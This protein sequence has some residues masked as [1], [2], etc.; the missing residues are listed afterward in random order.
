MKKLSLSENIIWNT[1][2]ST[3]YLGC[4]MLVVLF[5]VKMSPD[6]KNPGDFSLVMTIAN[7]LYIIAAY[8]I[9]PYQ[10][11]DYDEKYANGV[12]IAVRIA[13]TVASVLLGV[14]VGLMLGLSPVQYGCLLLYTTFKAS[15][16]FF[17][18]LHGIAQNNSRLDVAGKS[19]VLRGLMTIVA[20][21]GVFYYF[22]NLAAAIFAM[23]AASFIVLFFYDMMSVRKFGSI[24]PAF[25][26][27][28][29]GALIKECFP[30]VAATVCST[31]VIALP[32]Y[33]LERMSGSEALGAYA[34]VAAPTLVIQAVATYITSPMLPSFSA[35]YNSGDAKRL[36]RLFVTILIIFAAGSAVA[37]A[38]SALLGGWALELVYG[39]T[40]V[41]H[42]YLF[43]PAVCGAI[44]TALVVFTQSLMVV[45]R[46]FRGLI[47]CGVV[48]LPVCFAASRALIAASGA[49]GAAYALII[50]LTAVLT[51]MAA[52][53]AYR[54]TQRMYHNDKTQHNSKLL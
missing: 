44:L 47:I 43:M 9:R 45:M 29:V 26:K 2:G 49:K 5:V 51:L 42:I 33:L 7:V 52:F 36:I 28:P 41:P 1:I 15:E 37:V 25:D 6:Y 34:A 4:Q 35:Y 46:D 32:R 12:Y 13:T 10:V 40:I 50:A 48:G 23:S 53:S 27:T 18:V 31:A 54:L 11:S 22:R 16:A 17:D 3:F 38:L 24:K 14:V 21:C 20:F 8:G 39:P 30:V 19:F